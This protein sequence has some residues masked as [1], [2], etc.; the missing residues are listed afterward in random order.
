MLYDDLQWPTGTPKLHAELGGTGVG[1]RNGFA[2]FSSRVPVVDVFF[3]YLQHVFTSWH[4][5]SL[6]QF[7]VFKESC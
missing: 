1:P 2:K 6:E 3:D 5:A 7:A 4:E